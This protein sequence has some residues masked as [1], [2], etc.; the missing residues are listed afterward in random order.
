[1]P[2]TELS[3]TVWA[4]A[5]RNAGAPFPR[6]PASKSAN[7][8]FVLIFFSR[9]IAK[10]IRNTKLITM[11]NAPTSPLENTS[12]AFFIRIKELP[13]VIPRSIKISQALARF[14]LGSILI[15]TFNIRL[16]KYFINLSDREVWQVCLV[17]HPIISIFGIFLHHDPSANNF[18]TG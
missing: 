6:M 8:I 10:G 15:E 3:I 16:Q 13:Q 7:Q 12:N 2:A 17:K 9:L 14:D 4:F 1:M 5:K 18:F 11:R